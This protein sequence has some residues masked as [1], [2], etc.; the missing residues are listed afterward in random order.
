M[1]LTL[2]DAKLAFADFLDPP[3]IL[4][5]V[6]LL[7]PVTGAFA[8]DNPVV[9]TAGQIGGTPFAGPDFSWPIVDPAALAPDVTSS[10]SPEANA[11]MRAHLAAK[12]PMSFVARIELSQTPA[13][14]ALAALPDQG[15]LLFFYDFALG[16]YD[17]GSV[18]GRV[19]WDQT[20]TADLIPVPLPQP[21]TEA[22]AAERAE[23]ARINKEYGFETEWDGVTTI[24][25]TPGRQAELVSGFGLPSLQTSGT[26]GPPPEL[27][28]TSRSNNL[29]DD[30]YDALS[31]YEDAYHATEEAALIPVMRLL[32]VP[33]PEQD[34]PRLGVVVMDLFGRPLSRAE[35]VENDEKITAGVDD[36]L[37]LAQL[38]I[39]AWLG[40]RAEGQVYYLIRVDDLAARRFDRVQLVYQQT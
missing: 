38:D 17:D 25:D 9:A 1:F 15:N 7:Q 37:V 8:T 22:A 5:M 12:V 31:R 11:A 4:E 34:D 28:Q 20:A 36:W 39:A 16:P 30:A 24:H 23:I 6:D 14:P 27:V 32:S 29:D 21:L 26:G 18:T 40:D 33:L 2:D 19:I 13:I 35:W 3:H 10:G